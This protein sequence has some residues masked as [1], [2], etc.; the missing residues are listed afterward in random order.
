MFWCYCSAEFASRIPFGTLPV[1]GHVA[2]LITYEVRAAQVGEAAVVSRGVEFVG[3]SGS[4]RKR[5]R[6]N[7][8]KPSTPCGTLCACSSTCVEEVAFFWDHWFLRC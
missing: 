2:G 4:S 7:R 5:F 8:K 1:P 6:L 3:A